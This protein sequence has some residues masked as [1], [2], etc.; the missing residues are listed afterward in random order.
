MKLSAEQIEYVDYVLSEHY[1]FKN[2]DDVRTELVDHISTD[3][4]AE[5]KNNQMIL[6]DD[7]LTRVL[8][9]W[10]DEI[11]WDR[12]S[13]YDSV[14]KM[15][16][17]LWKKLDWKYNYC[18]LPLTTILC[19]GSMLYRKESWVT[20]MM[21]IFGGIGLVLG[22][23][24]MKLFSKNRFNTVLSIYAEDQI[25]I[26]VGVLVLALIINLGVNYSDGDLL[27][28]PA[29]FV[30]VHTTLVFVMR[31]IL[32]RKNIKIENQLLKVM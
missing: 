5:M 22:F 4:E 27:S 28:Q 16:S 7:A 21:Y 24:L 30:I 9:K 13:K 8:F 19:F 3:V 15:V 6:F 29:L 1:S 10:K 18:I 2:F 14:P 17:K 12:T 11:S 25:K 31:T 20:Y 23:Y 26:Y 32:M